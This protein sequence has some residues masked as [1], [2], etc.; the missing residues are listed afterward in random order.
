MSNIQYPKLLSVAGSAITAVILF[1]ASSAKPLGGL[2]RFQFKRDDEESRKTGRMEEE[3]AIV[4][5]LGAIRNFEHI[6]VAV[7]GGGNGFVVD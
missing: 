2:Q 3:N 7:E 1:D 6:R 4:V 5:D